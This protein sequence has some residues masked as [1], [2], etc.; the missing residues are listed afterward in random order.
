MRCFDFD[1]SSVVC[2]GFYQIKLLNFKTGVIERN[3]FGV[4]RVTT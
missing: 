4:N 1:V 3:V 2:P